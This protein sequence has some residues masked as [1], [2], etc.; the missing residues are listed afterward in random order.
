MP[1]FG[2]SVANVW[3]LFPVRARWPRRLSLGCRPPGAG[4]V[5]WWLEERRVLRGSVAHCRAGRR[6]SGPPAVRAWAVVDVWSGTVSGMAEPCRRNTGNGSRGRRGHSSL[7]PPRRSAT[8]ALDRT[9]GRLIAL[10]LLIPARDQPD[11]SPK[12]TSTAPPAAVR[13][14]GRRF[15]RG[16]RLGLH[17]WGL[18]RRARPPPCRRVQ[19]WHRSAC[20]V[21]AVP[22]ATASAGP[23][24]AGP[25][26]GREA[27]AAPAGTGRFHDCA[28]VPGR[29]WPFGAH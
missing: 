6:A 10:T 29:R 1:T 4:S 25:T 22:A 18:R 11:R 5:R 13:R 3:A 24:A 17:R 15:G 20:G 28:G 7:R 19:P 16:A 27:R 2:L 9:V 23:A 12:P 14:P 26:P 21:R 8:A